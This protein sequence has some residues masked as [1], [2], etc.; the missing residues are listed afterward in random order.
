MIKISV[1]F[2]KCL[3][4]K[5]FFV[6]ALF[7]ISHQLFFRHLKTSGLLKVEEDPI[8]PVYNFISDAKR[9]IGRVLDL[10]TNQLEGFLS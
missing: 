4:T 1:L 7:N 6:F 8:N 3:L 2:V 9:P 5:T 10:S